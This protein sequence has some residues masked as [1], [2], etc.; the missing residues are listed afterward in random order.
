MTSFDDAYEKLRIAE[1]LLNKGKY[2]DSIF[3]VQLS[4]ELSLK[5]LME[6]IGISY[7][8][9]HTLSDESIS[10]LL[11]LIKKRFKNKKAALKDATIKVSRSHMLLKSLGCLRNYT[12]YGAYGVSAKDL[13]LGI[14]MSDLTKSYVNSAREVYWELSTLARYCSE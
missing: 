4:V 5:T 2:A 3:N 11:K 6:V 9:K 1:D 12:E 7:P 13:F 8:K 10:H 14:H